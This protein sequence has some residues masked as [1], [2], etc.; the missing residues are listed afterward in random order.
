MIL[1]LRV[2]CACLLAF[3]AALASGA[4]PVAAD[5]GPHVAATNS[6]SSTLTADSCAGCHRAHTARGQFLLAATDTV[7]MCLACHG[8]T[9]AGAT[10]NVTDGVRAGTS[11][12]LRGGGFTNATMDTS[13]TATALVPALS[14]PVTSS[15]MVDGTTQVT[16]W[17]NGALGT[18]G[19]GP[20]VTLGCTSCH[21]PHG[22]GTYRIL[23]PI[24][25]GSGATA[26]VT[27]AD[28]QTLGY[29][30][31]SS[32]NRYFGQDYGY[33]PWIYDLDL[34]CAQC[35]TR[36]D[37]NNASPDGLGGPGHVP[38]VDSTY[39]FRHMT[40]FENW[41]NCAVC[42]AGAGTGPAPD[43]FGVGATGFAMEP[44]CQACHVVHGSAAQMGTFSGA[45]EWPDGAIAPA[46]SGRSSLLRLDNRGVCAGCH[47]PTA[48]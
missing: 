23:R 27:V 17:G 10:T 18:A 13:W 39:K 45:V 42:H 24:P 35:H 22:N 2:T 14:R 21:N 9:G 30:V 37:A 29:T 11:L 31:T 41:S 26:A 4:R 28:G 44:T 6:G 38:T 12:G 33:W 7:A 32:V 3:V 46:G 15:H 8:A 16:M 47:D 36:Y 48:R 40:R 20:S 19:V 1:F 25:T 34:W 43:P 5:G